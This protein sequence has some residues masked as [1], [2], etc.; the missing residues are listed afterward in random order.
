MKLAEALQ[1]RLVG[2]QIPV[3]SVRPDVINDLGARSFPVL[4]A[5]PAEWFPGQLVRSKA[6]RPDR[7]RIPTVPMCTQASPVLRS[8]L[9]TP[10]VPCQRLAAR[11]SARPQWFLCHP[12]LLRKQ[13]ARASVRTLLCVSL[14]LAL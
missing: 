1:G 8:V 6:L 11:M 5:C 14:A 10:S 12:F 9:L 4:R 7:Q 2:E 13:K 3:A